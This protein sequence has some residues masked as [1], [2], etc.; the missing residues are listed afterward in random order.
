MDDW[1]EAVSQVHVRA[2]AIE[3]D[4]SRRQ[5]GVLVIVVALL[6]PFYGYFV[7]DQLLKAEL[8]AVEREAQQEAA[9]L[10]AN[11]RANAFAT[12]EG[13]RRSLDAAAAQ[14][15]RRRVAAVR[16]VGAIEGNPAVVIVD[17]LPAE[18]AA[19]AADVICAQGAHWLRRAT[20]GLTFRVQRVNGKQPA[21]DAGVVVC[22]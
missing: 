11:V 15:L 7:W 5:L 17:H 12:G 14:D 6:A 16:V 18:G 1:V 4:W 10:S 21:T 9:A 20:R 22:P 8:R 2:T 19:E 3:S 13:I